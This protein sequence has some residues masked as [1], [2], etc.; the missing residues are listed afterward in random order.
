MLAFGIMSMSCYAT[1]SNVEGSKQMCWVESI[2]E[3][4]INIDSEVIVML[5]F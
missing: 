1:L 4:V 5:N 2:V 3:A